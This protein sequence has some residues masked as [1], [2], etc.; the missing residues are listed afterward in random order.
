LS[1]IESELEREVGGESGRSERFL[2]QFER[3][4]EAEESFA[5]DPLAGPLASEILDLAGVSA[6]FIHELAGTCDTSWVALL[7][8]RGPLLEH[9]ISEPGPTWRKNF[10]AKRRVALG[11]AFEPILAAA[12]TGRVDAWKALE[13]A[14]RLLYRAP[15]RQFEG[16]KVGGGE[17]SDKSDFSLDR[18]LARRLQLVKV[19]GG[20]AQ[21]V[22]EYFE[23][24]GAE[25]RRKA[26]SPESEGG[27][28]GRGE[29]GRAADRACRLAS[30]DEWGRAAA[31]VAGAKVLEA[32]PEWGGEKGLV[33]AMG[34]KVLPPVG[35]EEE[36]WRKA[37]DELKA[38]VVSSVAST[39]MGVSGEHFV[40][41]AKTSARGSAQAWGGWRLEHVRAFCRLKVDPKVG[42]Q[43]ESCAW[44]LLQAVG[45]I[46]ISGA[47]P[48]WVYEYVRSPKLIPLEKKAGVLDPRPVGCVDVLWRWASRALM[49]SQRDA[50]AKYL[51]PHQFAVG[52]RAGIEAM[53][54]GLEAE[55]CAMPEVCWLSGD[56]Q[57]AFNTVDRAAMLRAVAEVSPA[58]ALAVL[59]MYDGATC[60]R[61]KGKDGVEVLPTWR[62]CVQGDPLSMAV[63]CI[64]IRAPIRW[65]VSAAN[66]AVSGVELGSLAGPPPSELGRASIEAWVEQA[67]VKAPSREGEGPHESVPVK[68][69]FCADDG[70][71]R[72]PRW[73]LSSLPPLIVL[74]FAEIGLEMHPSKWEVWA[75]SF[76]GQPLT[77]EDA[78]PLLAVRP[79]EAGLVVAGAPLSDETSM[80]GAAAIV[81]SESFA[82]DYLSTVVKRAQVMSEAIVLLPEF[83]AAAYPGPKIALRLLVD[84]VK[85]RFAYFTRVTRPEVSKPVAR[86]FD[87]VVS[88]AAQRIF[89]W[90]EAEFGASVSQAVRRPVDGGVGL[91]PEARRCSFAYLGSWLD[92]AEALVSEFDVFAEV[93]SDSMVGRRLTLAYQQC[94]K[95]NPSNLPES[96][97]RFIQGADPEDLEAKYKR[98][99][100]SIRWQALLMRGKDAEEA[101]RWLESADRS[102]Q[103]RLAEMGGAWVFARDVPGC[104]LS[105]TLWRVAMRLRFGLSVLPA[106][107][108]SARATEWC[109]NVNQHGDLCLERLDAHGHHACTCQKGSQ[110]L[111]RHVV[112]VRELGKQLRYRGFFVRE[113]KWV[114][115]LSKREVKETEDGLV[116]EFKEARLDLVVRDG[117]HL[118]WLDFTCFHP[119]QGG[120]HRGARTNH[121]SLVDRE[122]DKHKTYNLRSKTG[123][124]EIANGRVVPIV[125]NTYAALGPEAVVFFRHATMVARRYGRSCADERLE[126]LVQQLVV[127]FVAAGVL[128]AFSQK[129]G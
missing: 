77:Q 51:E 30:L 56:V 52:R 53:I 28:D 73:L 115:E 88:A 103:R 84:C 95:A 107:P 2:S 124:R 80:P 116:V 81:G 32:R 123:T 44:G 58:L 5:G 105:A 125:A 33:A 57:N 69:R 46:L 87:K 96:L 35:D 25:K 10:P 18:E 104:V 40:R 101:E 93:E 3:E 83:A 47:A 19:A 7:E 108:E 8:V 113:E 62:G 41:A 55:I 97:A 121:W 14:M 49:F 26:L 60:Y 75:S 99:D 63:F 110:Q 50:L 76:G 34:N 94:V 72:S 48:Q 117:S 45:F 91:L 16:G 109:Q 89:G 71:W 68:P 122:K 114:D 128:D 119:F 4:I 82:K 126:P 21:L 9:L 31:A 61:Y 37:R 64:A 102:V 13:V 15:I 90:S 17:A 98:S 118:W 27:G 29:K 86:E 54:H 111:A 78:G 22:R 42:A 92:S 129:G 20:W 74:C 127:F 59:A 100:G 70:V 11:K 12:V 24:L 66:A 39:G 65:V 38:S 112:I 67:R 120:Q 43:P 106:L 85:P 6:D 36:R 23:E 79:P 1:E